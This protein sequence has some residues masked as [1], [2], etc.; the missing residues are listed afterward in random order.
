MA[1]GIAV[2]KLMNSLIV[3]HFKYSPFPLGAFRS[4][5]VTEA[6]Y[7]QMFTFC[8][9]N[10]T[11]QMQNTIKEKPIIRLS[12]FPVLSIAQKLAFCHSH[13]FF[14]YLYI[15][16]MRF[17]VLSEFVDLFVFICSTQF[18]AVISLNSVFLLLYSL[19]LR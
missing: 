11:I 15:C 9:I 17:L 19:H 12:L 18:S 14:L 7:F 4:L 10:E 3:V 8:F 6:I 1:F 2:E 16:N 5:F 13:C